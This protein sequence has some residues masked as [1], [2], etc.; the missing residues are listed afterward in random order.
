[1][2]SAEVSRVDQSGNM[3]AEESQ[4]SAS[5]STTTETQPSNTGVSNDTQVAQTPAPVENTQ[6]AQSTDNSGMDN[7]GVVSDQGTRTRTRLP[8]TASPLPMVGLAGFLALGAS[9]A[10]R[11]IAKRTV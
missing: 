6:V 3:T 8:R 7:S 4:Q 2:A 11:A 1:M 5:S 10:M 9:I